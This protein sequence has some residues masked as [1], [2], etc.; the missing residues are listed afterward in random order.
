MLLAHEVH[1]V[2]K[3]PVMFS[4]KKRN[5]FSTEERKTFLNVAHNPYCQDST[6]LIPNSYYIT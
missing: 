4:S 1:C 2:E 6:S 5:F 3:N